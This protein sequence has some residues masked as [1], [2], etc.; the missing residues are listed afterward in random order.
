M[1]VSAGNKKVGDFDNAI[2]AYEILHKEDESRKLI[3][4]KRKLSW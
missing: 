1:I 2:I 3:L 4:E